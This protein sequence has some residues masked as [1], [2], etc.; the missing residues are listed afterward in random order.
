MLDGYLYAARGAFCVGGL[1]YCLRFIIFS[2]YEKAERISALTH[3]AQR[4]NGTGVIA[5]RCAPS[6][7]ADRHISRY[8]ANTLAAA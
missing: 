2:V 3:A 1:E 8:N 4:R 6:R 5:E 7:Y